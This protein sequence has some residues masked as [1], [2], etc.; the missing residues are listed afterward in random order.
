[1]Q[2]TVGIG[3]LGCG[4]V[5]AMVAE[6]LQHERDTIER[7]SGVRYELCAIAIRDPRKLRPRSLDARL[8]TQDVCSVIDDPRVDLVVEMI[9]G[10][11]DATEPVE[12]A[13][14]RGRHVVTANK[15]LLATQGPR[16]TALAQSRRASLRFEA[17]VAGAIPILGALGDGLAGDRV[18]GVAGVFNGTCTSILSAME[19]GR[20]FNEALHRAQ[21]LGYAEADP[22]NDLDGSDAAHKLALIIQQA[23]GLAVISPRIR[24]TGIGA[25]SQ[26]DV[27]RARLLGSRI[28]L[29]A[30]TFR[31]PRGVVAEVA[32]ALVAED[33]DFART[34]GP[35][36]AIHVTT[37]H[38]GRLALRGTGAGGRAT[39]SAVIADVV[40]VL[41]AL[42]EGHGAAPHNALRELE[43]AIDVEPFFAS[44]PRDPELPAYA[45]WDERAVSESASPLY[46][47]A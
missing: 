42:G 4:T 41:R 31:T 33:H 45:V 46:A 6:R 20:S 37:Q 38:A 21:A 18:C 43:P 12:R 29:V 47:S 11:V 22:A 10:A 19:E 25:V 2:L 34:A 39:S 36:N 28:R 3:L 32:P 17:A 27:A 16:L 35:E 5:G 44:L 8:F 13:L 1:M 26:R 30:A 24:R 7:R 40:A 23:F 14:Y 15:E 9:G